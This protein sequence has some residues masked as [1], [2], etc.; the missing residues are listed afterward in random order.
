M[1]EEPLEGLEDTQ[2]REDS[3]VVEEHTSQDAGLDAAEVAML[4]C[5]RVLK[6][7]YRILGGVED[8][9]VKNE[10]VSNGHVQGLVENDDRQ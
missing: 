1:E 7:R 6:E 5:R 9:E 4:T 3:R 8:P 2:G 10:P